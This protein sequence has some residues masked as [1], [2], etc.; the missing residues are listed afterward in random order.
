MLQLFNACPP[1]GDTGTLYVTFNRGL[2]RVSLH[3]PPEGRC[4]SP[5]R[6]PQ[7]T[8][9]AMRRINRTRR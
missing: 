3:L 1:D 9:G 6:P 2:T 7:Y 4:D 5:A 8:V